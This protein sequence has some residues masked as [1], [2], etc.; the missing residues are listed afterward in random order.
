MDAAQEA[1]RA[2]D[3]P[4]T[5]L[6]LARSALGLTQEQMA[7]R[8]GVTQTTISDWETRAVT[9]RPKKWPT[10]ATA[11]GVSLG[12]LVEFFGEAA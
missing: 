7:E 8:C 9:P 4:P 12:I 10:V 5:V 3:A 6:Q 1:D 2:N 11:Y